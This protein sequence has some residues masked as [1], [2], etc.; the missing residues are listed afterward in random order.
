ML[1]AIMTWV[2]IT[3]LTVT[4]IVILVMINKIRLTL[5]EIKEI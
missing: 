2:F 4:S 3:G 5:N 1:D